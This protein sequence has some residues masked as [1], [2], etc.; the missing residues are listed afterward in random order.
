MVPGDAA[1]DLRGVINELGMP[2]EMVGMA[3]SM[4]RNPA[5]VEVPAAVC[6]S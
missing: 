6:G 3:E 2:P 4:L 5:F 1:D